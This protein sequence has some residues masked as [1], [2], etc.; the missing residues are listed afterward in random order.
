[1]IIILPKFRAKWVWSSLTRA[2]K[3]TDDVP[4]RALAADLPLSVT[5]VLDTRRGVEA[6]FGRATATPARCGPA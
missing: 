6:R 4:Q 5:T 3:R 2:S 1:M